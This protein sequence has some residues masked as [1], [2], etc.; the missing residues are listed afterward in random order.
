MNEL[1]G[2]AETSDCKRIADVMRM[3]LLDYL[4][5]HAET[6]YSQNLIE[7]LPDLINLID[8]VEAAEPLPLPPDF[9][10]PG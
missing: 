6:G 4:S 9:L 3:I 7:L 8:I 1:E 2:F 10:A 5:D